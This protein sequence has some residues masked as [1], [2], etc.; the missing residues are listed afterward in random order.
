MRSKR[1]GFAGPIVA[2]ESGA[3]DCPAAF[4]VSA[5]ASTAIEP[6]NRLSIIRIF[7]LG[8]SAFLNWIRLATLLLYTSLVPNGVGGTRK[9]KGEPP[10]LSAATY[11]FGG[12][13]I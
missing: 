8:A 4:A 1:P 2:A 7:E 3:M 5:T 9:H 11:G 13:L 12:R 10:D 6:Q